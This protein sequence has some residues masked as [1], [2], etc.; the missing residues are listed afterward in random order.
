M[1]AVLLST[2]G[3]P[4]LELMIFGLRFHAFPPGGPLESLVFA[5]MGLASGVVLAVLWTKAGSSRQRHFLVTGYLVASPFAF[6]GT[7][8]SGLL[9]PNALGPLVFGTP[10][11]A[12]GCLI[13]FFAGREDAGAT[14]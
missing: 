9:L 4:I 5:P 14:A 8:I 10:L 13:G 12:A 1:V 11:L 6:L 2:V 7:L 3:W